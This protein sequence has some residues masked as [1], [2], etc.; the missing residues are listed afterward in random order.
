[1]KK[2]IIISI[3]SIILGILLF[4]AGYVAF[5]MRDMKKF[6]REVTPMMK[7]YFES[8]KIKNH[9]ESILYYDKLDQI[10]QNLEQDYYI[11]FKEGERLLKE[12]INNEKQYID[13]LKVIHNN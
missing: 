8:V 5:S 6:N 13:S 10:Y 12:I 4:F 1:M 9:K 2:T 3:A 7:D 11:R